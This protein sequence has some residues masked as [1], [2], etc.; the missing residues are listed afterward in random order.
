MKSLFLTGLLIFSLALNVAVGM[1]IGWHLWETR[2][3]ETLGV[4]ADCPLTKSEWQEVRKLW[5]ETR[6]ASMRD[7]MQQITAKHGE[8]LA[9]IAQSP[10]DPQTADKAV[11]ELVE[12][13]GR[14]E[15]ECIQ[16]IA[17]IAA[18]LP[19]E[20]RQPFLEFVRGRAC[21]GPGLGLGR[22][23]RFSGRGCCPMPAQ[24]QPN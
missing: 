15:R 11:E 21:M 17:Q 14:I 9:L 19:A 4:G 3:A 8:I 6:Q 1:T 10:E 7:R 24:Q 5:K 18:K 12:L 2:R 23:G 16:R 20:K 22:K 13:K